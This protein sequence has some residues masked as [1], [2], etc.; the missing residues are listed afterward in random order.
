MCFIVIIVFWFFIRFTVE[1]MATR[2]T[3]ATLNNVTPNM[4][5][6]D[7]FPDKITALSLDQQNSRGIIVDQ[8]K[9]LACVQRQHEGGGYL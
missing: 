7:N 6:N 2:Q 8:K 4:E 9:R 5:D 3:S 1:N